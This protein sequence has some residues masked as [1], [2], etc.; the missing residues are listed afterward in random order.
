MPVRYPTSAIPRATA[1]DGKALPRAYVAKRRISSAGTPPIHE[2]R[3]GTEAV[4]PKSEGENGSAPPMPFPSPATGADIQTAAQ[5]SAGSDP[6]PAEETSAIDTERAP[7]ST[8]AHESETSELV[9]PTPSTPS[10]DA[11]SSTPGSDQSSLSDSN[12]AGSAPAETDSS[13]GPLVA[14][15]V[16]LLRALK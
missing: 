1:S 4:L 6:S 12:E 9:T 3:G 10:S 11:P 2:A 16:A 7:E 13:T 15:L 14:L 5:P 8:T